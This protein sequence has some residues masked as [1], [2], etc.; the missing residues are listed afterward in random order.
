MLP[1]SKINGLGMFRIYGLRLMS[2]LDLGVREF[3][4]EGLLMFR[5]CHIRVSI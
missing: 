1:R 3:G 5:V 2:V 4:A